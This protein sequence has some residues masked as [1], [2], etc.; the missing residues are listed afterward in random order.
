MPY[1]TDLSRS[2]LT[3]DYSRDLLGV[4]TDMAAF[5]IVQKRS[6][7]ILG[8]VYTRPEYIKIDENDVLFKPD[9]PSWV[10]DWRYRIDV[11][12]LNKTGIVGPD[13]RIIYTPCPGTLVGAYTS[14]DRSLFIRGFVVDRISCLAPPGTTTAKNATELATAKAFLREHDPTLAFTDEE[15]LRTTTVDADYRWDNEERTHCNIRR[16]H[17][18]TTELTGIDRELHVERQETVQHVCIFHQ[19]GSTKEGRKLGLFPHA[20]R[21][22]DLVVALSGGNALYVLGPDQGLDRERGEMRRYQFIGECYIDG[23]MDG[24]AMELLKKDGGGEGGVQ[25]RMFRLC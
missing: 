21:E 9:L 7:E 3:I 25:S 4:Y 19:V 2:G 14:S 10:P 22:G 1:A 13:Y 20:A 16:P 23:M 5:Y 18:S 17:P 15:F 8:Y 11:R 12:P 6:L 24:Q